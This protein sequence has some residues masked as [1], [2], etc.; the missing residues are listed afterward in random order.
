MDRQR[1]AHMSGRDLE[2]ATLNHN[3][4][5]HTDN[6]SPVTQEDDEQNHC[7]SV[8]FIPSMGKCKLQEIC[9]LPAY[10]L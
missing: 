2:S 9:Y 5:Q 8:G 10:T 3:H 7:E 6:G 4:I 1:S